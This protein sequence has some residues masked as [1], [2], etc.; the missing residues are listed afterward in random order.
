MSERILVPL[1]GTT[2]TPPGGDGHA[3]GDTGGGF[4]D[5]VYRPPSGPHANSL[6]RIRFQRTEQEYEP[7][8]GDRGDLK[9]ERAAERQSAEQPEYS[10][11]ASPEPPSAQTNELRQQVDALQGVVIE[12]AKQQFPEHFRSPRPP[13]PLDYDLYDD[14]SAAEFQRATDEYIDRRIHQALEPHA[15]TLQ[16]SK[17]EQQ[18]N[19]MVATHGADEGFKMK[20]DMALRMVADNNGKI[21]IPEA[22]AKVDD[23]DAA[24]PGKK[25][26]AHLPAELR[27]RKNGVRSLGRIIFHNQQTGRASKI[28]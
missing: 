26:S 3:T 12:M 2:V 21:S 20:M 27:D 8:W 24:R 4:V 13:N 16:N 15:A 17:W 25:G 18:Y 28:R 23:R 6:H 9:W 5:G 1:T 7:H 11:T 14:E 22:Y 19:A 10:D